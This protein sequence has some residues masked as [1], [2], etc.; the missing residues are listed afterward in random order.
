MDLAG[1]LFGGISQSML[2]GKEE[3]HLSAQNAVA[4]VSHL[5]FTLLTAGYVQPTL[6]MKMLGNVR[7]MVRDIQSTAAFAKI[8]TSEI[9][10][11]KR[12][13]CVMAN[14]A[15]EAFAD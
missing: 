5:A 8:P 3:R 9:T 4:E 11:K 13:A 10:V 6:V 1:S 14:V 12:A 15:I 7:I 2:I